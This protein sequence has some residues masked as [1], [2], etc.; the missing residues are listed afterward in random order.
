M[1]PDGALRKK[2][3]HRGVPLLQLDLL[4]AR[5]IKRDCDKR[6]PF[7][8]DE[9]AQV[10]RHPIWTGCRNHKRRHLPGNMIMQDGLYWGPL[11]S[12]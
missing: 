8:L 10:F 5:E 6:P 12:V 11:L 9:V 3:G 1:V 2:R 7:T 4:R